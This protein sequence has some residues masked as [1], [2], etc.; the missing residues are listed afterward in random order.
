MPAMSD[1]KPDTTF[2]TFQDLEI[3]AG[4]VTAAEPFPE[5]RK[6]AMK[7][8]LDFGDPVGVLRSSA[9]LTRRYAPEELVG[10]TL[11][12]V[13]NFPPRRIAGFKSECL[14]LG[15]VNPDDAGDIVLVRPDDPD[16]AGWELG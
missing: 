10:R 7:L 12:A 3:R 14:V 8:T 4:K 5:A 9:Q 16:S 15:V 2:D 11:L 1:K 6:P 13:V